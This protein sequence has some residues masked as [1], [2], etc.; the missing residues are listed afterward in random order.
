MSYSRPPEMETPQNH[1]PL[2]ISKRQLIDES[3]LLTDA[4]T[5]NSVYVPGNTQSP[6][7][8][9]IRLPQCRLFLQGWTTMPVFRRARFNV[10]CSGC[11]D[12]HSRRNEAFSSTT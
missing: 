9:K 10:P 4:T 8:S 3:R 5:P 11:R 2:H 12:G 1:K 7:L 6:L